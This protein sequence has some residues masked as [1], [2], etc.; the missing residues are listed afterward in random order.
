M[1]RRFGPRLRTASEPRRWEVGHFTLAV[2]NITDIATPNATVVVS[3]GQIAGHFGTDSPQG[4]VLDNTARFLEIG[5]IIFRYRINVAW[6]LIDQVFPTNLSELSNLCQWRV[7]LVTDRL[8]AS[9]PTPA[10]LSIP[11]WFNTTTPVIAAG[12]TDTEDVDEQYPTRIHWQNYH[13]SNAS[14]RQGNGTGAV[15]PTRYSLDQRA[16]GANLRLR[17]RLPDQHGL[18][19]HFAQRISN[20]N[21][22]EAVSA[23]MNF[24]GTMYYR[25]RL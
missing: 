14:N 4:R 5:G 18:F 24:V 11:N 12:A 3:M 7:L 22:F 8:D 17:T 1:R 19:L 10:P 21:N 20:S 16:G 9:T 6:Q 15:G 13:E 23:T 2:T 25:I